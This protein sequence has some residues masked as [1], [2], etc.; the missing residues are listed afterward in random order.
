MRQRLAAASP[1]NMIGVRI[2]AGLGVLAAAIAAAGCGGDGGT[3]TAAAQGRSPA[4][5]KG[6]QT[7]HLSPADFTTRIDNPYWPMKPGSRWVYQSIHPDD[8]AS[9]E[10][11]V[12]RVTNKTKKI[13]NGVTARVVSDIVSEKGVATEVTSDYY[14]QDQAG[15]IWY[16]GEKTAEYSNG[17]VKSTE[18]SFE[19]G[20]D[21]AQPG[22]A[23]P[24]N[25]KPGLSYRQEYYKGQAEDEGAVLSL[26]EQVETPFGHF[27]HALMTRDTNPLEPKAEELKLY[28]RGVGPM[29]TFGISGGTEVEQLLS[30]KAG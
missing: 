13:A 28:A 17:K 15:N 4:L 21:G 3:S 24:A 20:V 18:G 7:V 2:A 6:S 29:A 26:D 30:Y 27:A 22:I 12:V 5:P 9:V 25:P 23:L 19:A 8:L 10:K 1:W 11:V 16:M 14:A